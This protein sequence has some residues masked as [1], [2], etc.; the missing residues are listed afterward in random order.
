MTSILASFAE[1]I[2]EHAD[3]AYLKFKS[4][5]KNDLEV[6]GMFATAALVASV[7]VGIAG[8]ALASAGG[9]TAVIGVPLILVSL[10]VG[11]MAYNTYRITDN[12]ADI[13]DN[14]K[15]Y[16][17]SLGMDIGHHQLKSKLKQGTVGA[18]WVVNFVV[19]ELAKSGKI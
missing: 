19:S 3:P 14:P 10:P 18:N 8:F 17:N 15:K 12:L 16:D 1:K 11:Y 4:N 7:V 5:A 6:V 2:H 9:L 13:I